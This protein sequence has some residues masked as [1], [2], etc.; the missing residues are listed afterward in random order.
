VLGATTDLTQRGLRARL[1]GADRL[2]AVSINGQSSPA[3][4]R[5][6]C[7]L[8][9]E[10]VRSWS[11]WKSSRTPPVPGSWL[12][13]PG[14]A[15]FLVGGVVVGSGG[16]ALFKGSLSVI[17]TTPPAWRLAE[18]LAALLLSGQLGISFS[19]VVVGVA[20]QIFDLL[21]VMHFFAAAIAVAL[22]AAIPAL[23][24]KRG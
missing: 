16:S 9:D 21:D 5:D 17:I 19:V 6:V 3:R 7:V 1:L 24:R 15:L 10:Q 4:A 2:H 12:L 20:L 14:L 13:V 11:S 18:T 8:V 22:L 23:V